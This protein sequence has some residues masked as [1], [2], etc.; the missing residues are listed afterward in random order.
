MNHNFKKNAIWN[1]IGIT[2]NSFNS[3][4]FLIIINR[5]NGVDI[6]GIFS[7]AFSVACLLYIVGIYQGRIFQVSDTKEE[8][9]NREYFAHKII[10]CG[11]MMVSAFLF[12]FIKNYSFEKKTVI[13]LLCLYKCV[14]AFDET[15]FAYL[16]K[17]DE[18]Y[19][20]G[21]SYFYR[22][23]SGIVLF[24]LTD[25][26]K[27][28]LVISC[29]VLLLNSLLF[30]IFYDFKN[31]LKY[32][33]GDKIRWSRVC[34]LYRIGFSVFAFLFLSVYIVNIPKYILDIFMSNSYQTIFGIIVMPGTVVSLCGQYIT[35]P[36]LTHIVDAFNNKDFQKFNQLMKKM[37]LLLLGAGMF[38]EI[39]AFFLGIPV[40][41]IVY[42][43]NL[44]DYKLDLLIIIF[45][46][47]LYA[48]AGVFSTAMITMRKNNVQLIIYIIDALIGMLACYYAI[49]NYGIHGATAGYVITM[50][51]HFIMYAIIYTR[52]I[53]KIERGAVF[54][55]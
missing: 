36:V 10:S 5:I 32:I 15:L 28:N 46:A 8:L 30:L 40:L 43:I 37:T 2:I 53:K 17:N 12:I 42:A 45:G 50:S 4:F 52:E 7:F 49:G 31:S 41:N 35:S 29:V 55:L 38:I 27:K 24:F 1:T 13:I 54:Q 9:T 19:L 51:C 18:L 3:L 21:K 39:V 48:T 11:I 33:V 6:A 22:S 14:E 44:N 26:F 34:M 25:Y 23:F 47:L 20:V 16:Q